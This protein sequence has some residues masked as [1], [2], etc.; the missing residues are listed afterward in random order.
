MTRHQADRAHQGD[1][2]GENPVKF[3]SVVLFLFNFLCLGPTVIPS[4]EHPASLARLGQHQSHLSSVAPTFSSSM[5]SS[6]V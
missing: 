4:A 3:R 5:G 2:N 6:L 1:S